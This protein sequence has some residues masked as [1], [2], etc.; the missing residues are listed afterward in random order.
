MRN[1]RSGFESDAKENVF[2][3]ADSALD[4]A[5]MVRRGSHFLFADFESVV[6]LGLAHSRPSET[7][8][9]LE[10]FRCGQT[11][12]RLREI[13]FHFVEPRFAAPVRTASRDARDPPA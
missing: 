1:C 11:Q 9:D 3:I 7:G 4:P 13:R 10:A 8:T 5:G 12:H 6:V 2:A